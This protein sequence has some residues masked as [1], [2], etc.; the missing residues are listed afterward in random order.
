MLLPFFFV[1][2]LISTTWALIFGFTIILYL[3]VKEFAF[4][5]NRVSI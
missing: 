4:K 3:Y 1:K 5:K 2:T